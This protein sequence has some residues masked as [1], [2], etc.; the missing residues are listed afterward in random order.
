MTPLEAILKIKAMFAEAGVEVAV[1]VAEPVAVEP[2]VE[3]IEA[4][5]E[6]KL[7]S[8]VTVVLDKLEVGGKVEV[9][10]EDGQLSP[11]PAGEHE[12]A[13]GMIIILDEASVIAEI[14][15]PVAEE[16]PAVEVEVEAAEEGPSEAELMKKKIEEMQAELDAMKKKQSMSEASTE[17]FSKAVEDL[18]DIVIG[19]MQTPSTEPTEA[20]KEKFNKHTESYTE[21]VGKFLDLAKSLKK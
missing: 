14:K 9:K 12:M 13:D 20:P 19:L 15:E 16:A 5:K 4:A 17:K 7:K 11:A 8:G 21:K 1:P 10:G 6:Y 2:A 3:P 18:T